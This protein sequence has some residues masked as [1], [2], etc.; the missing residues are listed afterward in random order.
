MTKLVACAWAVVLAFMLGAGIA[1][2]KKGNGGSGGGSG[3]GTC[4]EAVFQACLQKCITNMER[5]NGSRMT[6]KCS[7]HC[8][9]KC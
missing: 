9:N 7:K 2:A 5:S 3:A 1:D 6:Q 8:Q 4:A